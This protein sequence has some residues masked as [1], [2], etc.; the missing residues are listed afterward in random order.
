[1]WCSYGRPDSSRSDTRSQQ[2]LEKWRHEL[3]KGQGVVLH[4]NEVGWGDGPVIKDAEHQWPLFMMITKSLGRH[5]LFCVIITN[6]DSVTSAA[7]YCLFPIWWVPKRSC[8]Y[9][10]KF[11]KAYKSPLFHKSENIPYISLYC[12]MQGLF[13]GYIKSWENVAQRVLPKLIQHLVLIPGLLPRKP[14]R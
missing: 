7:H 5:F 2:V 6:K 9:T 4:F 13:G 8:G 10:W 3:F 14:P 1:M 11:I 12:T